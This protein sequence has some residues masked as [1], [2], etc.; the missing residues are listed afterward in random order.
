M[1][2]QTAASLKNCILWDSDANSEINSD[3]ASV[4]F[5]CVQ[6]GFAGE[7]NI[8]AEPKIVDPE[9]G[10]FRLYGG[11]P[12]IDAG[13][14]EEAP[15]MDIRG[16][17][18]PQGSG[19]DMGAY[20]YF[21]P[22]VI[23]IPELTTDPLPVWTWSSD[24]R[25]A[26][27]RY[28]WEPGVWLAE[29]VT[30][31]AYMPPAA[32]EDGSYTLYVQERDAGGIWWDTGQYMVTVD[33]TPPQAPA[34]MG[35]EWSALP[36]PAWSWTSGGGNGGG[37]YRYG[38]AEGDWL[39]Q[40]VAL[41]TYTPEAD[42]SD[43]AYTL[44]VQERDAA[45]NWSASGSFAIH[46]DTIAPAAPVI[47]TDGG[48]G[49]GVDFATDAFEAVLDGTVTDDAVSVLVNGSVEGV[50]FTPGATSWSYTGPMAYGGNVFEVQI[51]DAAG[52]VSSVTIHIQRLPETTVYVSP[53]G[54]DATGTGQSA[55][56]WQTILHAMD[57]I[58]P[59]ATAERPITISLAAGVYAEQVVFA[60]HVRIAGADADIPSDT[61]IA[62][63]SGA[64]VTGHMAA[65]RGAEDTAVRDLSIELPINAPA[66]AVIILVEDVAMTIE[67]T[68]LNGRDVTGSI[69]VSILSARS[70]GSVLRDSIVKRV[71]YGVRAVETQAIIT[72]NRFEDIRFDAVFVRAPESKSEK[73]TPVVGDAGQPDVTGIN[74]FRNV[75]G[76]Y[77][78]N[79]NEEV[80]KAEICDWGVYTEA[81]IA[82][83]MS[84]NVDFVPFLKGALIPSS[85]AVSVV[86]VLNDKPITNA[87]ISLSPGGLP[88][89]A[90]NVSGV[91][92]YGVVPQGSYTV[93]AEAAG[94]LANNV[95]VSVRS[96]K[97]VAVALYLMP[98]SAE[99]EGDGGADGEGE[100]DGNMDG[101]GE[102]EGEGGEIPVIHTSD[103]N[104]NGRIEL[105]ELLRVIQF[106]N[107]HGYHCAG[108]VTSEDGYLPGESTD[109]VCAPH[110]SDYAPQNWQIS[111]SELLRLI[112]FFNM[113]S[114]HA[115]PSGDTEDGYCPG[116]A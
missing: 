42:L 71:D 55:K 111:L 115:C 63:P 53:E 21:G 49:P 38:F 61:R 18:R 72:R 76:F 108:N 58:A 64:F 65:L 112:Q 96:D 23:S 84:G 99:G 13:V 44:Y 3:A 8:A 85:V 43:G 70:S 33:T 52:N 41:L 67:N 91:Y 60:P 105:S 28:G 29:D 16:I 92:T 31:T 26:Y 4:E 90:D 66:N 24:G 48:N 107:M 56:P 82:A 10:D 1:M 68:L 102:G 27:Y 5:S 101:E 37:Y 114:Y 106:F 97:I 34:V 9:N 98:V 83:H 20:E 75:E 103:Q 81:E 59:Y 25:E 104:G 12:C 86:D 78:R 51:R 14:T 109:H 6:G 7:G 11:S 77:I 69:G 15:D 80:T 113:G 22:T 40:E 30:D 88:D 94:Y 95:A 100:G 32:L 73:S 39:A 62:P 79:M 19:V 57:T 116:T 47:T 2:N 110:G 74:V 89:V 36:R 87:T 46:V 45:G 17:P 50:M 35:Q 54:D 93:H